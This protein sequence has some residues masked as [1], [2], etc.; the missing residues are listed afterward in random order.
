MST[1]LNKDL[2]PDGLRDALPPD[3]A[4][5]AAIVE[6]LLRSI[7][8]RGYDRVDPPLLEFEDSLLDGAGRG[9][10]LATFR[11]MDPV[12]QRMMGVRADITPQVARIAATRLAK[13][14][15]PLRLAYAG[16][17]LRV[18]GDQLRPERQFY[19]VG[20]ELIGT[21][22]A[23]ADAEVIALAAEA[24]M[25]VGVQD[26]SVDIN[27]PTLTPTVC[28]A[29][30]LDDETSERARLALDR[31]D[32]AAVAA[33][34]GQAASMLGGLL[35]AT[36]PL[37]EA[38]AALQLVDLPPSAR[39]EC[40][41]LKLVARQVAETVP[42]LILT[43]DPAENRGFEYHTGLSFTLFAK[44]VR[45]S[46]G[47]GG[48][49]VAGGGEEP[50]IGFTLFLDSIA[51]AVPAAESDERVFLPHGTPVA[52]GRALRDEG[53]TTVAGF[54]PGVEVSDNAL[55]MNCTHVLIDGRPVSISTNKE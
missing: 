36:G 2:L 32:A 33:L 46:L 10:E 28:R 24:L 35:T 16:P 19:E 1:S 27:L 29:L 14:A 43:I 39:A 11:L 42:A 49:Y 44:G 25:S 13:V 4:H 20:V 37:D 40:Q 50:A 55:R 7:G 18:R 30:E 34:G 54:E 21:D 31:K 6:R 45:G 53:W 26:V 38:L 15:R 23:D 52:H 8:A 22:R 3:A 41:R 17:V 5:E 47:R 12:S 48:R 51:R 9:V